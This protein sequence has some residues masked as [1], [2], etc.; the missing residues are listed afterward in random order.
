MIDSPIRWI[1]GKARQR[2]KLVPLLQVAPHKLYV[3]VFG[4]AGWVLFAKP[5]T[6][7]EVYND[8]D[9]ELVNF[10]RV[11]QD[12][13]ETFL[14]SCKW[15]LASREW[16]DEMAAT[17]PATLDPVRR[18]RRFYYLLMGGFCGEYDPPRLGLRISNT[19]GRRLVSPLN[20]RLQDLP[21]R[22]RPVHRR[23]QRVFIEHDDWRNILDRYDGQETLFY[24][25]PPYP[26]NKCGYHHNMV[27]WAEHEELATRLS[28]LQ[29]RWLLTLCDQPRVRELYT[30][31]WH[32][33]MITSSG[34]PNGSG[35][36]RAVL[37]ELVIA[38]YDP[39]DVTMLPLLSW[40]T[41]NQPMAGEGI[42]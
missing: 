27:G 37:H 18:A 41:S 38:N 25:D 14:D 22:I 8:L 10:F 7:A 35:S 15:L 19:R 24:L 2:Q 12:Q 11:V 34:T 23:L 16:F 39:Y 9:G 28:G 30:G 3:E 1:G 36:G 6:A 29:G 33:P 32:Q 21:E 26:G 31:Y 4:G 20:Y 13:T 17:D 40:A 5:P 42:Q